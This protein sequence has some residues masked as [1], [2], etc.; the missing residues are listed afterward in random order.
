MLNDRFRKAE[1]LL[2]SARIM[3]SRARGNNNN[4]VT[5]VRETRSWNKYDSGSRLSTRWPTLTARTLPSRLAGPVESRLA[6]C[7]MTTTTPFRTA[8]D[9]KGK[10][11]LPFYYANKLDV[12]SIWTW[13]VSLTEIMIYYDATSYTIL[14][15]SR[16]YCVTM[17]SDATREDLVGTLW[18]AKYFT[19]R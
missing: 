14:I 8:Y 12:P 6:L 7:R 10:F 18:K 13:N 19:R 2:V 11:G 5:H 16:N 4:P 9:E 15:V 3:H 17:P 1:S